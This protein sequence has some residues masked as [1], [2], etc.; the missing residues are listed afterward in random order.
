[1][2]QT[3]ISNGMQINSDNVDKRESNLKQKI[4]L[5]KT[6][7]ERVR[8][9]AAEMKTFLFLRDDNE[10]GDDEIKD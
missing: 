6:L 9:I 5:G 2:I 8:A 7:A 3:S 1:M 4:Q 10:E